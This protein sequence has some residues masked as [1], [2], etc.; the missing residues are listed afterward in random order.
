MAKKNSKALSKMPAAKVA[1]ATKLAK[2][3]VASI[4]KQELVEKVCEELTCSSDQAL[5]YISDMKLDEEMHD[6]L[7]TSISQGAIAIKAIEKLKEKAEDGN[8]EAIKMIMGFN[9]SLV[10]AEAKGINSL[11]L[12]QGATTNVFAQIAQDA[13]KNLSS[14]DR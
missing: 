11:H 12:H 14:N 5:T 3:L 1:E 7:V 13:E 8:M 10:P 4:D 9:K 2:K 6:M